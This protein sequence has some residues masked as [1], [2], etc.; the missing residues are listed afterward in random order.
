MISCYLGL[1]VCFCWLTLKPISLS[2]TWTKKFCRDILIPE[3]L[4]V[5]KAGGQIAGLLDQQHLF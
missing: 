5:V 1:F 3:N 2:M 4:A